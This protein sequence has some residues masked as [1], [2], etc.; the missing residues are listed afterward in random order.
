MR[1][2]LLSITIYLWKALVKMRSNFD[3]SGSNY[4]ISQNPFRMLIGIWKSIKFIYHTM[5]FNN[6]HHTTYTACRLNCARQAKTCQLFLKQEKNCFQ[7]V[8]MD[9]FS[10]C[11]CSSDES[12]LICK[13]VKR[14][15]MDNIF[16]IFINVVCLCFFI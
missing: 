12:T 8:L 11:S 7:T 4:E 6:S 9:V 16:I 15:Y 10:I 1:K 2:H 5:K 14:K 3:K 13:Y